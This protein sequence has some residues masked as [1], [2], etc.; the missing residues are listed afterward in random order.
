MHENKHM[1]MNKCNQTN[2]RMK[3]YERMT[4]RMKVEV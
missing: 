2:E 3:K 4:G 1:P